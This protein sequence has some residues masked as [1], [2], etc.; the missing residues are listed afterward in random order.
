MDIKLSPKVK[1]EVSATVEDYGY[2]SEIEFIEDALR[3]R[4]L[5][6]KKSDF[7]SKIKRIKKR[8]KE[9]GLTEKEIIKDFDN[10]SH[11]K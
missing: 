10:F 6:L 7:L 5:E 9:K 4:I 11:K 8:M 3:H 2:D 1:R